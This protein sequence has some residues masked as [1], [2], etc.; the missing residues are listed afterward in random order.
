MKGGRSSVPSVVG[1]RLNSSG[2]RSSRRLLRRVNPS[3]TRKKHCNGGL[4]KAARKVCLS[5]LTRFPSASR[6]FT[7][8]R[9][10]RTRYLHAVCG[11]LTLDSA[12]YAGVRKAVVL[13]DC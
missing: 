5:N 12:E 3:P 8:S 13:E 7:A 4:L 1:R 2:Q 11:I 9:P 10:S 6:Q